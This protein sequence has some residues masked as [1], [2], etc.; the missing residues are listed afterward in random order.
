MGTNKKTSPAKILFMLAIVSIILALGKYLFLTPQP[1]L[2]SLALRVLPGSTEV[3]KITEK[4]LVFKS[5]V[6]C[7]HHQKDNGRFLETKLHICCDFRHIQI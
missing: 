7:Q 5:S 6:N 3:E 1:E 2:E 4:P